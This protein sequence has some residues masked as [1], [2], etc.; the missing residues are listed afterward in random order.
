MGSEEDRELEKAA[1]GDKRRVRQTTQ[2]L[3][4]IHEHIPGLEESM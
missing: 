3:R 2:G 4:K 1:K